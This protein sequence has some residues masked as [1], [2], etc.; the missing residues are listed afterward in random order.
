MGWQAQKPVLQASQHT[1]KA[2]LMHGW[3]AA[4]GHSPLAT[5]HHM[6]CRRMNLAMSKGM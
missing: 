4:V 3:C 1:C 6:S 2:V 5:H